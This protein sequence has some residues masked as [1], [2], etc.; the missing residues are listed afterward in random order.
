[1]MFLFPKNPKFTKNFSRKKQVNVKLK[2]NK[3]NFGDYCL[4]AS[5]SGIITN[6]QIE[7]TR[8]ILRRFLKKKKQKYFLEC[9][10]IYLSRKNLMRYVLEKVRVR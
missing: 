6:F 2:K 7:A 1:M 8:R 3:I 5:E 9:T 10:Q 4:I